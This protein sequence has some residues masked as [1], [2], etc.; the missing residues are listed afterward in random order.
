MGAASLLVSMMGVCTCASGF[1]AFFFVFVLFGCFVIVC[2]LESDEITCEIK[3]SRRES[4]E[5]YRESRKRH[6][7]R[8]AQA[9]A[10]SLA[11]AQSSARKY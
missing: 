3:F 10:R 5:S 4:R 6:E 11:S 1:L 8:R 9:L 2:L 7:P